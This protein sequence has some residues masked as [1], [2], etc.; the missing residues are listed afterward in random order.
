MR[1]FPGS[2]VDCIKDDLKPCIRENN[3]DDLIFDVGTNNAP[4]NK[5]AKSMAESIESLAK[6]VKAS[7]LDV[8]ISSIIPHNDSWNN[9]VIEVNSYLKDLCESNDIPFI[10]STTINPQKYLNNS[11]VQLN[12]KGPT[13][14]VIILLSI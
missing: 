5:K 11:P 1:Q 10:S 14:F 7:K 8:S 4:S 13:N 2:K 12:S 9:K 3:P 6:E